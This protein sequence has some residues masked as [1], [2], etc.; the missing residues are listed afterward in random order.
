MVAIRFTLA[1]LAERLGAELLGDPGAL[2]E[3]VRPLDEAGPRTLFL[4]N[5]ST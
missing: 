1:E 4:H 5:P 2:V 3:G